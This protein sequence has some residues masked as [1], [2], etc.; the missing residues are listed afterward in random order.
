MFAKHHS[1][2]HRRLC[3]SCVER[4][5]VRRSLLCSECQDRLRR[6]NDQLREWQREH[7]KKGYTISLAEEVRISELTWI[8]DPEGKP[9]MKVWDKINKR[10][11]EEDQ[12][13]VL[14]LSVML[15]RPQ[16]YR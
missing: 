7:E 9:I 14:D 10:T 5:H 13:G 4:P 11:E 12:G 8:G 1:I 2:E 6:A 16:G 15:D 3:H